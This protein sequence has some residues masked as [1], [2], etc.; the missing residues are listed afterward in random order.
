M[1]SAIPRRIAV[2]GVESRSLGARER[3]APTRG[4]AGVAAGGV[5][6]GDRHGAGAAA[7]AGAGAAAAG[8]LAVP[9]RRPGCPSSSRGRRGR[10]PATARRVDA[11]LG[12]DPRDDRGDERVAAR[13]PLPFPPA[14]ATGRRLAAGSASGRRLGRDGLQRPRAPAPARPPAPAR[15]STY[16]GSGSGTLGGGGRLPGRRFGRAASRPR[17]SRPPATR[18]S[19]RTPV[20]GLGTSVSTLSVEISSSGSSARIASPTCFSHFVTVPSETETPICGITT[21]TTVPV[22]ISTRRARAARRRRRRPAAGTPP[23]ARREGYRRVRRGDP[24]R[25]RVEILEGLLGDRRRDL[26]AEAAGV[27][28]LVQDDHLRR[29]PHRREHRLLVPRAGSCAGR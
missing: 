12:G 24:L 17:R 23:R 19:C 14:R 10:C 1:C 11:V 26:G 25:R 28:V 18:I 29:L 9:R 5:G 16:D 27:R 3:V 21:S 2:I 6:A 20:P 7:A 13:R 4:G 15:G 22:A 8:G